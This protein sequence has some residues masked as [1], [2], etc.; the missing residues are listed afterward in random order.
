MSLEPTAPRPGPAFTADEER[1]IIGRPFLVPLYVPHF[2]ARSHHRTREIALGRGRRGLAHL[3]A[4]APGGGTRRSGCPEVSRL[5]R[6]NRRSAP[7]G[8][9]RRKQGGTSLPGLGGGCLPANQGHTA[10]R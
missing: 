7:G 6:D 1:P 4:P 8:H 9:R 5:V 2:T 3:P 10:E